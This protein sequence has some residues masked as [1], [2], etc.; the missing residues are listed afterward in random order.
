MMIQISNLFI[1]AFTPNEQ[2]IMLQ[3]LLH[4]DANGITEFSDRG[5]SKAT[6]IPYQQ[7]RTIHQRWLAEG[8]IS[9]AP[10]NAGTNAN[11]V[12]VS[13]CDY[14]SYNAFNIF[15]NAATNAVSNALKEVEKIK[16][17]E[18]VSPHTPLQREIENNKDE[19][20]IKEEESKDSKK[21]VDELLSR[22]S[23]LEKSFAELSDE[24]R[25]L[26]EENKALKKKGSSSFTPPTLAEVDAYIR[27]K[28]YH[29]DAENFINFYQSKGWMVGKNK[30]KDWKASC[31]TWERKMKENSPVL[32]STTE[33]VRE[34]SEWE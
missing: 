9:N 15:S 1:K 28:G 34:K 12:Y 31:S 18:K 14:D 5:I 7:V 10:A 20:N 25:K 26:Q 2:L 33:P 24:N 17:K 21:K 11:H 23:D 27:E 32:F 29:F 22:L 3:L 6:E 19:D 4:A 13:V 16:E 30:M 8:T